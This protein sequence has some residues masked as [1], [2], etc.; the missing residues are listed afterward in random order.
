MYYDPTGHW[1]DTVIDIISIGWS[2]YDF[3]EDP[4][5]KNFGWLAL[6]VGFALIPFLTGSGGL[7][8]VNKLDDISDLSKITTKA[9]DIYVRSVYEK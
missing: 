5:W 9:D 8:A 4:S 1:L 6:D 2:L 7:K 3:I